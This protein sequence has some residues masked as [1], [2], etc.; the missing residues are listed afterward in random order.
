LHKL[1][2]GTV[3]FGLDYGISNNNGVTSPAEVKEI[4][5]YAKAVGVNTIDTAYAYGS[6]EEILGSV[7]V[8]GFDIVTKFIAPTKEL[9]IN[10]QLSVSLNRLGL[11][12]IYGLLAHRPNSV[13]ENPELWE[14]LL[15]LKQKGLVKKIGFSFNSTSEA[16]EVLTKGFIPDIVQVPFNYIDQ[17]FVPYMKLLKEKGCDIH[18]RSAFLQGLF[19]IPYSE[20]P[21]FFSPIR[22]IIKALQNDKENLSGKLL[23]YCVSQ[24]FIDKVVFGVNTKEQLEQNIKNLTYN[25]NLEPISQSI[26]DEILT[27]SMWPK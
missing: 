19:F 11:S 1:A 22:N 7:G 10:K 18:T 23:N 25:L 8:D 16:E 2:L 12:S 9:P 3:Q 21:Q 15:G 20:L 14:W 5:N 24:P 6:S 17:R 4:L 26:S 27:P 13:V